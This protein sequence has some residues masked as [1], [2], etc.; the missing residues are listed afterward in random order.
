M[1]RIKEMIIMGARGGAYAPRPKRGSTQRGGGVKIDTMQKLRSGVAAE[2]VGHKK[3][4]KLQGGGVLKSCR[5][6]VAEGCSA[7]AAKQE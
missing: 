2:A 3:Q 7:K 4:P 6:E 5:A 1:A